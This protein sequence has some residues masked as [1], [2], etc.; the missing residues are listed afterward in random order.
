MYTMRI[1][2]IHGLGPAIQNQATFGDMYLASSSEEPEQS[3][4]APPKQPPPPR[5]HKTMDAIAYLLWNARPTTLEDLRHR[6][7]SPF[8]SVTQ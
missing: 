7:S 8:V 1:W 4:P 5:I 2:H 3:P 6:G